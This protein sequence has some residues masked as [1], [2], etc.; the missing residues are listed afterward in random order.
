[1]GCDG[2]H[3]FLPLPTRERKIR[4]EFSN[5]LIFLKKLST[6]NKEKN[7]QRVREDLGEKRA[8]GTEPRA[9]EPLLEEERVCPLCSSQPSLP[10]AL[11][12]GSDAPRHAS[13][14]GV[15]EPTGKLPRV[16]E[17]KQ[18][19]H[20][21]GN[22]GPRRCPLLRSVGDAR[23]S[24]VAPCAR[25]RRWRGEENRQVLRKGPWLARR[26]RDLR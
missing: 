13:L 18:A 9:K 1:M 21:A 2:R 24:A 20:V 16:F 14:P 8:E 3:G 7:C 12:W 11:V 4:K 15:P 23:A 5:L 19:L 10:R 17:A 6:E 25:E 26:S 22:A